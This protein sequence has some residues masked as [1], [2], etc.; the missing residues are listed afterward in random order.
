[1]E[2]RGKNLLKIKGYDK[3]RDKS[4]GTRFTESFSD[5]ELSRHT[6]GKRKQLKEEE[7][8]KGKILSQRSRK[9]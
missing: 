8:R 1:L 5:N 3:K 9:E 7:R 4:A 2:E 6:A